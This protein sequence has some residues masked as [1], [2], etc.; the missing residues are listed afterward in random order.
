MSRRGRG[1]LPACGC[2]FILLGLLPGWSLEQMSGMSWSDAEPK[3]RDRIWGFEKLRGVIKCSGMGRRDAGVGR[4]GAGIKPQS[5]LG[6]GR[7]KVPSFLSPSPDTSW[8]SEEK[9]NI[10]DLKLDT[11]L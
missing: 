10:E 9:G 11:A 1:P 6:S 4:K 3:P 7:I 8:A 2:F 5:N